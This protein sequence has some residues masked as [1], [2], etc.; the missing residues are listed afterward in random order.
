MVYFLEEDTIACANNLL[1]KVLLDETRTIVDESIAELT[2]TEVLPNNK[3]A[4]FTMTHGSMP[5]S[6]G[7]IEHFED[8][9]ESLQVI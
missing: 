3:K 1:D 2:K 5:E 4:V 7:F 8:D 6:S 9:D